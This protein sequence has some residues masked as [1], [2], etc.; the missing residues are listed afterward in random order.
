MNTANM[1]PMT[2]LDHAEAESDRMTAEEACSMLNRYKGKYLSDM[3]AESIYLAL[4][5]Y[6]AARHGSWNEDHSST[7]RC[8]ENYYSLTWE[9]GVSLVNVTMTQW[10]KSYKI[11]V[12]MDFNDA[13]YEREEEARQPNDNY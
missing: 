11:E 12:V 6:A 1:K 5:D 8:G 3:T 13:G 9:M 2:D 10:D 4:V 7:K